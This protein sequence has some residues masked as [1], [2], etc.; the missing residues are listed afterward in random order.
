MLA[1]SDYTVLI[2]FLDNE[3][4]DLVNLVT[5]SGCLLLHMGQIPFFILGSNFTSGCCPSLC[6]DKCSVAKC[7]YVH[8]GEG[9]SMGQQQ[10]VYV[11]CCFT[12]LHQPPDQMKEPPF[13][14]HTCNTD[15]PPMHVYI[16]RTPIIPIGLSGQQMFDTP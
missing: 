9:G 5:E 13:H 16:K 3:L 7:A 2:D 14:F 8:R 12:L 15:P 4:C 10:F 1:K 6:D 11:I